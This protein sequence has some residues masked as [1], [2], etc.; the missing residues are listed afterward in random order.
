[1]LVIGRTARIGNEGLATS[2]YNERDEELAPD[3]V[4]LL[5]ESNQVIP[6]FLESFRP[7]EATLSF[8]DDSTDSEAEDAKEDETRAWA[9]DGDN[10][11]A[12]D[13]R[14][15][16]DG[17]TDV[18]AYDELAEQ[19]SAEEEPVVRQSGY[20]MDKKYVAW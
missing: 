9:P 16:Q 12:G 20:I 11:K 14:W 2:F 17:A 15:G 13:P 1:L 5:M 19:E 4:K 6:E 10:D 7:S 18:S 8:D 3:L